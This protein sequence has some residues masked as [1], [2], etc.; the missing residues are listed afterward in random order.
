MLLELSPSR[1]HPIRKA[2]QRQKQQHLS[3]Q[4]LELIERIQ[5]Y[6]S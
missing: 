5:G 6:K 2:I 1:N 4:L 3:T